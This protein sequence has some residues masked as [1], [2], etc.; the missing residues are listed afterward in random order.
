MGGDEEDGRPKVVEREDVEEG[1]VRR[2]N[3]REERIEKKDWTVLM[4]V[5]ER[6]LS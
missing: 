2:R 1:R 6:N 3:T 4:N 5:T